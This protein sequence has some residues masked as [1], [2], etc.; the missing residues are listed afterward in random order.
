M[1]TQYRLLMRKQAHGEVAQTYLDVKL[2]RHRPDIRMEVEGGVLWST[3]PLGQVLVKQNG[4][5]VKR[6]KTKRAKEKE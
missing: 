1:H 2:Q 3:N 5:H 6:I 4:K